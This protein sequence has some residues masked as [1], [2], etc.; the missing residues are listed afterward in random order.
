M[1]LKFLVTQKNDFLLIIG[2]FLGDLSDISQ[3]CEWFSWFLGDL[4]MI[5]LVCGWFVGGLAGL[6]VVPSFTVNG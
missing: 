2:W 5:W 3:V 1:L 6:W 4:L